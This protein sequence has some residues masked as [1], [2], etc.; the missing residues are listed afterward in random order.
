MP[1]G[2]LVY[3]PGVPVFWTHG[4]GPVGNFGAALTPLPDSSLVVYKAIPSHPLGIVPGDIVL[5]Y[6][7]VPWKKLY[8]ELLSA[9]LP[10]EWWYL[11]YGSTERSLT[12]SLL[13]S[14]GNNWG[15]FDTVDVVKYATGDTV[16]LSTAP[17]ASLDWYSLF[18]SEQMPIPGIPMPN[19]F[20]GEAVKWGIIENTSIG[21]VYVYDW[22]YESSIALKS[23][24]NDLINVKDVTGLILDFRFNLGTWG[25]AP[26]NEWMSYLFSEVPGNSSQW[27]NAVRTDPLNHLGFTYQNP[28]AI[29]FTPRSSY[30]D[31]PIAVLTGPHARS[32]GDDYAFRMRFHPMVRFFG[33]PTN[34]SFPAFGYVPYV[35]GAWG[36]W[37]YQH[38]TAQMQSLVSKEGFL[39]HK[40]FPVDE[41]VWL[42]RDG[43]A[44][45]EDDVVKAAINWINNYYTAVQEHNDENVLK[46][47]A[48]AQNYPNPFNPSTKISWQLP[49]GSQITLKVYDILGREVA[50]LVNEY[51][52]SGKYET[53]FNAAALPSGVYF[54][55]L[56]AG[57]YLNTKK[58]ILL[59]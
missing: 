16:H 56:K 7:G 29:Y 25:T 2:E 55:Q 32:M 21:Y 12:H 59:K 43:V 36:A 17:L 49:V 19:F 1:S 26:S 27:R 58:M 47:Y 9:E 22:Q 38:V 37:Y 30:Y 53:E 48:L 44:K 18:S 46:E 24:L 57:E 40:G 41:E 13:N 50:T 52:P 14:A 10:F 11:P 20:N 33:L 23:A 6:E 31:R 8:K 28:Q 51:K 45:G 35:E 15:L 54:Y 34:G 42:T 3:K 4:W 39:M 5:G